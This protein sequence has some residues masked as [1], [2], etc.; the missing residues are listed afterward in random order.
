MKVFGITG[1]KNS[2]KTG[3]MERVVAEVIARGITVSTIKHAHHDFDVDQAGTDSFR[4]RAAGAQ[5]VLLTSGQRWALMHELRGGPEMTL[6]AALAKLSPVDLVLV[7]G[8]KREAHPKIQCHRDEAGQG[9]NAGEIPNVVAIA[10]DG[11]V[12]T[13]LPQFD[14]NDTPAIVDFLLDQVGLR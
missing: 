14:L 4:H 5:E 8:F 11:R 1:W 7:E 13:A 3:L 2:G 12:E 6:D 9:F 10:R